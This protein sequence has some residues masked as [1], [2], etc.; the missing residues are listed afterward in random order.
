MF[1]EVEAK[2]W[3]RVNSPMREQ[4]FGVPSARATLN[5]CRC[6]EEEHCPSS[7][8]CGRLEESAIIR[9]VAQCFSKSQL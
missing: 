5:C 7:L 1:D 8:R 4:R 2:P 9:V 6:L 3:F